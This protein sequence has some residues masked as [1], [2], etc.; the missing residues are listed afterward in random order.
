MMTTVLHTHTHFYVTDLVVLVLRFSAL[1]GLLAVQF[2][3]FFCGVARVF[4][5]VACSLRAGFPGL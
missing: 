4:Y 5:R 2:E 3:C 1:G